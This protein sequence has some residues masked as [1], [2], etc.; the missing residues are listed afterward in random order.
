MMHAVGERQAGANPRKTS[1]REVRWDKLIG[2]DPQPDASRQLKI[3]AIR[4][5][6]A[7]PEDLLRAPRETRK[8]T[9]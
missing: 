3:V 9:P 7:G 4:W 2:N 8:G 1:R 5:D 6:N